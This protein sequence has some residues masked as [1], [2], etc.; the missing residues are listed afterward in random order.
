MNQE[1][2]LEILTSDV[3]LENAINNAA[4]HD[5]AGSAVLEKRQVVETPAILANEYRYLR[6]L[7]EG[8]NGKTWLGIKLSTGE[9]LAIKS[10]KLSQSENLK[11]FELFQ[12]EAEVLA[13]V[14]IDGVPLFHKSIVSDS[15]G[16]ECFIIQQFIDSPSILDALENGRVFTETETLQLMRQVTVIL[17]ALH[18]EYVP[19]IIHRDI[20]PSNIL[21]DIPQ[22]GPMGKAYLIDFGAVANP[23]HKTGGSTVAG[24]YGYMPPEQMVGECTTASDMYSLGATALHMITGVPPYKIEADVFKLR[25]EETIKEHAP[26]T[27]AHMIKLIGELL[28]TEQTQRISDAAV[29]LAKIDRVLENR[30]PDEGMDGDNELSEEDIEE[31]KKLKERYTRSNSWVTTEGVLQARTFRIHECFEYTFMAKEKIS[32]FNRRDVFCCGLYPVKNMDHV[33]ANL[34]QSDFPLPCKVSYN[35]SNPRYNVLLS[36]DLKRKDKR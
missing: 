3:A 31:F 20:K 11:S 28:N 16:G 14:Q 2:E 21:C 6:L 26:K 1:E 35:P 7:G 32:L 23:Q 34:K 33:Y 8:A 5:E 27:S 17:N 24:T 36:I 15:L 13:S 4:K 10:L 22:N 30:D 25:Y 9:Q 18:K 19:P 29:L 12:R